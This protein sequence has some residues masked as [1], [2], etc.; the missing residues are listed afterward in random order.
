M[1]C[2]SNT[3]T[4]LKTGLCLWMRT[5]SQASL[6]FNSCATFQSS[7]CLCPMLGLQ[8]PWRLISPLPRDLSHNR[9]SFVPNTALLSLTSLRFLSVTWPGNRER[10]GTRKW[11]GVKK[12]LSP[13]NTLT[14]Y[15]LCA[16]H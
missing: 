2:D 7:L 9:I 3:A 11:G 8:P 5:R 12:E 4:S 16:G 15:T 13:G 1:L 10:A 6:S 14:W